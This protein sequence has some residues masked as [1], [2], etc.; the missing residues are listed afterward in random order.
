LVMMMMPVR[1]V[2]R[3][4]G[5]VSRRFGALPERTACT[6][7]GNGLRVATEKIPAECETVTLGVWIDAGSR[8]EAATNNGSAHFL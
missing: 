6:T 7:L 4:L 5:G 2:A 1:S 3:R 8:Y